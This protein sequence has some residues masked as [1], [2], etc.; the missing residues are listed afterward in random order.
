MPSD[1]YA[2]PYLVYDVLCATDIVGMTPDRSYFL[3]RHVDLDRAYQD[4]Q[5][6]SSDKKVEFEPKHS[7]TSLLFEHHTTSL[8]FN[9]LPLRARVSGRIIGALT[10]RAIAGMESSLITLVDSRLDDLQTK[11][12]VDL[13]EDFASAISVEVI[14]NLLG[15]PQADRTPLCGWSLVKLSAREPKLTTK[16]SAK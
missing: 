8:L 16:A 6:F 2:N 10:R 4:A 13:I 14:G 9:E 5:T 7:A 1:F 11:G 3:N 12:G 15:G